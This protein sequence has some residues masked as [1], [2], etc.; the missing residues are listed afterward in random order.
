MDSSAGQLWCRRSTPVG[1]CRRLG[2]EG[3]WGKTKTGSSSL[4]LTAARSTPF[5]GI[6]RRSKTCST[7]KGLRQ[8]PTLPQRIP[9][10]TIGAGGLNG[11]VRNGNG[12]DPSAI[13]AE[14]QVL[15]TTRETRQNLKRFVCSS[16]V[17]ARRKSARSGRRRAMRWGRRMQE[18][19]G[20]TQRYG[21]C[22][23]SLTTD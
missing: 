9:C 8:C 21:E 22:A 15:P 19:E 4:R 17:G 13:V 23:L 20:A 10:S 18:R 6:P 11:R 3:G 7:Q 14:K 1:P 5:W 2:P 16:H 12:C